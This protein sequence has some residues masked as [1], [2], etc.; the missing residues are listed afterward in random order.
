MPREKLC[1]AASAD[2][3]NAPN[4]K[5]ACGPVFKARFSLYYASMKGLLTGGGA[6]I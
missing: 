6:S 4:E 2:G 5:P 3:S 1:T